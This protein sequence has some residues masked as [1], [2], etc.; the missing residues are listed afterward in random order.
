M[1]SA[2]P[3][4]IR[5]A[6]KEAMQ[7]DEFVLSNTIRLVT[8]SDLEGT[9][10]KEPPESAAR[11][12]LF[13][14]S[15]GVS[16]D[17][18]YLR[19]DV[20]GFVPTLGVTRP[21]EDFS[22]TVR[23]FYGLGIALR[24]FRAG[25]APPGQVT[26]RP[27]L[28]FEAAAPDAFDF[29]EPHQFGAEVNRGIDGIRVDP[30]GN[31]FTEDQLRRIARET[32]EEIR[33]VFSADA[34]AAEGVLRAAQWLFDSHGGGNQLLSYVQATVALEILLGDKAASD[35]VGLGELLR[36][37]CAYLIGSS[38]SQREE[39]LDDFNRIYF[40]RSRIVHQGKSRLSR[41]DLRDLSR[42][43]WMCS[44]V[45]QEEVKLIRADSE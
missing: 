42:L 11:A 29:R 19:A 18:V 44:R 2:L 45:I 25:S 24:L 39:I 13:P 33:D 30:L 23:A 26:E 12:G 34:E 22:A 43:R 37:R 32:L 6:V 9:Y 36:N 10:P 8:G 14:R 1:F 15:V 27:V 7:G 40:T 31:K 21:L 41:S 38:R 17:V 20:A 4:F 16:E 28:V 35:Q 5:P 3:F